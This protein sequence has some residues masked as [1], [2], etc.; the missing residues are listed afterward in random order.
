MIRIALS[1]LGARKS[2][3]FGAV[4]AVGLA[5]VLVVSCGIL[6]ESS[7]RTPIPVERLAAA[8]VVVQA[9]PT[10]SGTGNVSVSL[11]E[12]RRLPAGLAEQLRTLPG[13]RAAI[14]DRSF[15]TQVIDRRGQLLTGT[16][17]APSVGHGWGSAALTP[18]ALTSGHAPRESTQ[19]VLAADLATRGSVQLGDRLRVV[20]ATTRQ[21]FTVVGTAAARAGHHSSREA[22]V[23]FRDDVATR[24]SGTGGRA[25]LIGILLRPGAD[26]NDV[27]ARVGEA[28]D[29]PDLRLL[30]GAKRGEAESPEDALSQEDTV[31]G[32]TVF[33]LLAAFVAIFVVASTFALSVQQRHREFALF[34]AIGST[35][36]QVRQMVAA[37]ALL[38]SLV[39]VAGAAPISVLVVRLEQ[40]LFTSAGMLPKGLHLVVG[41]LPFAAGLVAAVITTQLAAFASARRAARIS[42]TDALREA[43][44]Q[45]RPVSLI[46]GLAGLAVLAGGFA[47]LTASSGGRES[48]APAS[49][50]VWMLGVAL[51]GPL[52]AW[53]FAW[54]LGLPLAAVSRGPGML[55][56]AN[57]RANLRRVASVATPLMLAVSLVCTIFYGKTILERQTTEQTAQRTTAG[58]VLRART[59]AGLPS[60]TGAAARRVP[61][62]AHASGSFAT[63]V[64]VAADGIN[65]RS[66]PA[67]AVDASTLADVIDLGIT[68]GS[69]EIYAAGPS[70]SV[71]TARDCSAGTPAITS[72]SGSGTAPQPHCASPQCTRDLWDSAT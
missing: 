33:A 61:G 8:A 22:A 31:A 58:Y 15:Y 5:V 24:L 30:T 16:D 4:V 7:L 45:R 69:L 66:F 70:Q 46:R 25:D 23:F 21:G 19:I 50:M 11:S 36:R 68:S 44:V 59:A 52:L 54:L 1:T 39:A 57:T 38:V 13:V 48:S 64:V 3:M 51:L 47:V 41:W 18:V 14:A 56:R 34:R 65:L 55:A 29:Q 62:V 60:D 10:L 20:T 28:V 53:P 42:P 6:L 49:A 9:K 17:R 35:P 12:R 26:E 32:L 43:S 27:A 37:E 71:T 2:G 67:R 72:R 63:S 40:G